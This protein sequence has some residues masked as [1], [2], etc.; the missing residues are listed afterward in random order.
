NANCTATQVTIDSGKAISQT[1]SVENTSGTL[2]G[3]ATTSSSLNPAN[4]IANLGAFTTNGAFTLN[5]TTGG[6]N[7]TGAVSTTNNGLAS[8]TDRESDVEGTTGAVAGNGVRMSKT[9][10]NDMTVGG[11]VNGSGDNVMWM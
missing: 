5:D 9:G 3:Y 4:T 10:G 7:V 11:E 8:I 1:A 6:L 2:T